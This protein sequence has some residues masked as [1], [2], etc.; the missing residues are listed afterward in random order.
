VAV[1]LVTA[2]EGCPS[3]SIGRTSSCG[4][5]SQPTRQPV[6]EKYFE[7]LLTTMASSDTSTADTVSPS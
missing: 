1:E 7:K 6:I 4:T 5:T 2:L 3:R